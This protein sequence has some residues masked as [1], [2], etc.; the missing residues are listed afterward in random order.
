M[1]VRTSESA[2][3]GEIQR[4]PEQEE[5]IVAPHQQIGEREAEARAQTTPMVKWRGWKRLVTNGT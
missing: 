5:E 1:Q 2:S 3:P 4:A